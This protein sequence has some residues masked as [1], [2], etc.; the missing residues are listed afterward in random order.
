[1][2]LAA[3]VGKGDEVAE[4][5]ELAEAVELTKVVAA[6]GLEVEGLPTL[7]TDEQ[8]P[9]RPVIVEYSTGSAVKREAAQVAT[10]PSKLFGIQLTPE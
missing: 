3:G 8:N 2:G 10:G 6:G 7:P 1:M 5:V 4:G 9:S